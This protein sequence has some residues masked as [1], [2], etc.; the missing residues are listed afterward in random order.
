MSIFFRKFLSK[1]FFLIFTILP[2]APLPILAYAFI[3]PKNGRFFF[4]LIFF[5]KKFFYD[6]LKR[7]YQ[8][9]S[10]YEG[11]VYIAIA[12]RPKYVLKVGLYGYIFI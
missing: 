7:D 10:D 12:V 9:A 1:I 4:A 3:E 5:I 8:L 6:F 11:V 2:V